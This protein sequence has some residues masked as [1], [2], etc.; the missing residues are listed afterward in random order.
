[1]NLSKGHREVTV[2]FHGL[3]AKQTKGGKWIER[4]GEGEGEKRGCESDEESEGEKDRRIWKVEGMRRE[5]E[6]VKKRERERKRGRQRVT[7]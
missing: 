3:C 2:H 1:M 7:P 4:E 6:S 5:E